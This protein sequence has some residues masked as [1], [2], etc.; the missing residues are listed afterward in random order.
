MSVSITSQ[1][2]GA[3]VARR[4]A[5]CLTYIKYI[6]NI[7][8]MAVAQKTRV[9][10]VL[11]Q[12]VLDRVRVVAGRETTALKL[13][14]SVQIVLRALI[15]NGLRRANG[16][17]LRASITGHAHAVRR[18]RSRAATRRAPARAGRKRRR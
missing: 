18:I 4:L 6:M 3:A 5:I 1:R 7:T 16:Q 15:E 9:L 12:E 13:P 10:L 8:R 14:V 2:R 17:R 11:P